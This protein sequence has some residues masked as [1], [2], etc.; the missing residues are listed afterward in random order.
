DDYSAAFGDRYAREGLGA[1]SPGAPP[2]G[3]V[4]SH[5]GHRERAD[6]MWG[7]PPRTAFRLPLD[8]SDEAPEG[9]PVK[10]DTK[11]GHHFSPGSARYDEVRAE[12]WFSSEEFART[13]GFVRAD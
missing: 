11:T 6:D 2:P 12:I 1:L 13:N 3:A 5:Q 8:D 10:A 9:Y 4:S 7:A